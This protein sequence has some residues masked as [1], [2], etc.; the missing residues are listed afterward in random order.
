MVRADICLYSAVLA[1]AYATPRAATRDCVCLF[2]GLFSQRMYVAHAHD[3]RMN[4]RDGDP[5]GHVANLVHTDGKWS[6][7]MTQEQHGLSSRV[8]L[9]GGLFR[10]EAV[11][12]EGWSCI[13]KGVRREQ[14]AWQWR[15]V[16]GCRFP[17]DPAQHPPSKTHGPSGRPS[18]RLFA[19]HQGFSGSKNRPGQTRAKKKKKKKK[20]TVRSRQPP[21][22]DK[23]VGRSRRRETRLNR[24]ECRAGTHGRTWEFESTRTR[25]RKSVAR[26]MQNSRGALRACMHAT[27]GGTCPSYPL[28]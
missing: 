22:Q 1:P 24:A 15:L 17:P 21:R 2:P 16:P 28:N 9:A 4:E 26:C 5:N 19:L 12:E 27:H 10:W 7:D 23:A 11:E 3:S 25:W 14:E 20:N 13:P 8:L 18:P 6:R